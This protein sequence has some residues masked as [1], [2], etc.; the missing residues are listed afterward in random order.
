MSSFDKTSVPLSR[1]SFLRASAASAVAL[2]SGISSA[3]AQTDPFQFRYILASSLYGELPL[4]EILPEVRKSGATE[5]DLWP[6]KHGNQREQ[7]EAMGHDAFAEMLTA[8]N[9]RLG[10]ITRYDLGPYRLQD[11][12]VV[13]KKFGGDLIIA[14]SGNV[15]GSSFRERMQKFVEGMKPH[16]AVAEESGVTIGIENHANALLETPDS[17]RYLA[18]LSPSDRFGIA[19]AP[20]HLPQDPALLAGLI[21]DIG[22]R[23]VHFYAWEHGLGCHEKRPKAQEM[24]QLPGYGPLDF[25][26]IV[27]AL[28]EI[29][30]AG[31]TSIFMHPVPRGIPILPTAT[32]VTQ[33]LN[34]SREYLESLVASEEAA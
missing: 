21:K 17:L 6:R 10:M 4:A 24:K 34:R 26:P 3:E 29:D 25:S 18:E 11:E 1:R 5:I 31:R 13:V 32:E 27:A 19:F 23:L 30:Y 16:I 15:D 22:P 9:V 33:A 12:M 14:G 7:V 8:H 2:V 20:Y 28:R